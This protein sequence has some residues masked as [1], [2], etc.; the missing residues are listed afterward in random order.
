MEEEFQ[1]DVDAV[2]RIDAVPVILDVVC[3]ATGMGFAAVARVTEDRWIACSVKVEIHFGLGPGGELDVKTTICDEIRVHTKPVMIDN[4]DTDPKYCRHSTPAKYGFKSYISM[5]IF[6]KDGS[7]FGTL[8]AIDPKP[9]QAS[10]PEIAG[11]FGLFADLIGF[12][13]DAQD[14]LANS[15]RALFDQE[16]LHRL[17]DQFIAVLGHDLRNPLAS[18]DASARML[19]KM[20]LDAKAQTTLSLMRKS[21]QRMSELVDNVLD[22]ARGRLGAGLNVNKETDVALGSELE[23]VI[24]EIQSTSP[25]SR[26][27]VGPGHHQTCPLRRVEN[28]P[29]ALE[30]GVQC[31]EPWQERWVDHHSSQHFERTL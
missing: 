14:R 28:R 26:H 6:K 2:G 23:H 20:E 19:G 25:D 4:V 10:R 22:F 30:P 7:F 13:L 18:I 1:R 11:M 24:S 27:H 29:A 31:I 9:A 3:R 15:E 12:Y 16:E 5:P 8:C 21:I 17:R